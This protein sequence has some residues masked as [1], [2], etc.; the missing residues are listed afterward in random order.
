[1]PQG[2]STRQLL[3]DT[4]LRM[5]AERGIDAVSLR[6]LTAA[7]GQR[8]KTAAQYHFGSREQ[9]V[10]ELFEQ[11]TGQVNQRRW[12]LLGALGEG[13]ET[14]ELTDALIRP[15]AEKAAQP[16]GYYLRFLAQVS[17]PPWIHT[18]TSADP[19]VTSSVRAVLAALADRLAHLPLPILRTRLSLSMMLAVRAL[20]GFEHAGPADGTRSAL[21]TVNIIDA[22]IGMLTAPVSE[23]ADA[24][25]AELPGT[26]PE[27]DWPWPF[28]IG[29]ASGE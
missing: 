25:L 7:A 12:E 29:A 19:A 20:A 1:M 14:R 11:H 26:T 5:F 10:R 2:P 28:L 15:L 27:P 22:T 3:A 18:L 24:L 21:F 23:A 8:N 4:A 9:L 16:E 13:A 6:E 17:T